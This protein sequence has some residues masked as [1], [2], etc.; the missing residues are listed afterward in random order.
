MTLYL[1]VHA[2]AAFH[3]IDGYLL[4]DKL[5]LLEVKISSHRRENVKN[6]IGRNKLEIFI[7]VYRKVVVFNLYILLFKRFYFYSYEN[8]C[9]RGERVLCTVLVLWALVPQLQKYSPVVTIEY[10]L[11]KAA[12]FDVTER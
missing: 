11:A 5:I 2:A 1:N 10:A 8:Q 3:C 4:D 6:Q 7:I 12:A 9:A